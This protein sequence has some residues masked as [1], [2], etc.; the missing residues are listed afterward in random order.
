MPYFMLGSLVVTTESSKFKDVMYTVGRAIEPNSD[1]DPDDDTSYGRRGWMGW[2]SVCFT[3]ENVEV[4][5]TADIMAGPEQFNEFS[6][7]SVSKPNPKCIAL[8]ATLQPVR[9]GGW[10]GIGESRAAVERRFKTPRNMSRDK[11]T[12]RF[13]GTFPRC[14]VDYNGLAA[15][16]EVGYTA[17]KV[18]HISGRQVTSC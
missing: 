2:H 11:N 8:P 15:Y 6:I 17:G 18:T 13:S 9:V 7:T 3:Y 4:R 16:V 5:F 12:Y 14:T 1:I 10:L